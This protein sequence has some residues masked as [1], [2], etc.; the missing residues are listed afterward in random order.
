MGGKG[1]IG[2]EVGDK[3]EAPRVSG[4]AGTAEGPCWAAGAGVLAP[5]SSSGG[6]VEAL[7]MVGNMVAGG[8]DSRGINSLG[9]LA[10]TASLSHSTARD[11]TK[12]GNEW[13]VSI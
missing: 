1:C 5:M 10:L 3:G 6:P 8:G 7:D 9:I 11:G 4:S 13:N 12:L 2:G